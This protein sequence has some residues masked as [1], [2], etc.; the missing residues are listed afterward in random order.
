MQACCA[1]V[2]SHLKVRFAPDML[3]NQVDATALPEWLG[4]ENEHDGGMRVLEQV[5]FMSCV[6][7]QR[8]GGH[9]SSLIH[10]GVSTAG[11]EALDM[12]KP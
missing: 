3:R 6:G 2:V 8:R 11:A 5:S 1:D 7:I 10:L 9:V 12:I 4:E